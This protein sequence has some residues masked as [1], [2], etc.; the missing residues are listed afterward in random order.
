MKAKH[1]V[2][3]LALGFCT[4]FVAA[5]FKITHWRGADQLFLA[6]TLLKIAGVLLLAYKLVTSRQLRD[7]MNH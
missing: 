2:I 7:F 6:G 5:F 3:L 4:D 1:A